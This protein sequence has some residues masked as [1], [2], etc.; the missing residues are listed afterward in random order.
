MSSRIEYIDFDVL[1]AAL[2]KMVT[3]E[4]L[5]KIFGPRQIAQL[6]RWIILIHDRVGGINGTQIPIAFSI[7]TSDLLPD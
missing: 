2:I 3:F 1:S 5:R 4:W 7:D 6:T